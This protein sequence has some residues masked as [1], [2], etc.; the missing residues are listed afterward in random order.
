[1]NGGSTSATTLTN[2]D[3]VA[4]PPAWLFVATG[5]LAL[6]S[7]AMAVAET[8]LWM[9][10]LIDAGE[11]VSLIGLVFILGAGVY[12][13]WR[14]RLSPSLPLTI[15][16][17]LLPIITQGDQII[18]NLSI[19]WMRLISH[20]LLGALFGTPVAVAVVAARYTLAPAPESTPKRRW[21]LAFIPG[22]SLIASGRIREGSALL[23]AMMLVAEMWVAVQ[24]LGTLM[25]VT[26]IVMVWGVL[27]YGSTTRTTE[28]AG[29][30]PRGRARETVALVLL[31]AGVVTSLALFVGFKNRP[32]A[33]QGSPSYFM[34]PAQQ[35]GGFRLDRIAVPKR[36][37]AEPA[38][39]ADIH[40]ALTGYARALERLVAGYYILDRNYNYDFHNSLFLRNTPLLPGYR[41][42]GLRTIDEA[43]MLRADADARAAAARQ[44]LDS[45][46]PLAAL[47]DDVQAYVAFS[48][49]RAAVLERMSGAFEQTRA[50]LQHAT[51]LYEGEGK[52]VGVRLLELLNKHQRV[53]SAPVV[54]P[55]SSEFVR[56]SRSVYDK[57][58]NRVVGF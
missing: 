13:F 51:H 28:Y 20:V 44:T 18:D 37:A 15:P 4:G 30:T 10:Y 17:L 53:L 7:L 40:A 50:G 49:D 57:Y 1:V 33:Y 47:L 52:V 16:W 29:T 24:F 41:A 48:F 55:I 23:A 34:D 46:D 11:Y 8:N 42:V 14:G 6:A 38:S 12:L 31:V 32:G 21:W 56:I 3:H 39:P 35:D 5:V 26:L 9:H 22:L 45:A 36:E 54:A 43:E 27:A 2:T 19:N 58:A 25:I